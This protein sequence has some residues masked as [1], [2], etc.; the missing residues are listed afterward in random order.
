MIHIRAVSPTDV[1][2]RLVDT[3]LGDPG[4]LDLVVLEGVARGPDGDEVNA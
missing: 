1:T 2:P 4:V 3:L